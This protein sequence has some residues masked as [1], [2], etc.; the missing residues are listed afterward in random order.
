MQK[1]P[2]YLGYD[3][4]SAAGDV[5]ELATRM[6]SA[7]A[8]GLNGVIVPLR[9]SIQRKQPFFAFDTMPAYSEAH[10]L[11][12]AKIGAV[13]PQQNPEQKSVHAVVVAFSA[14]S[15]RPIAFFD[16]DAATHLKCAAVTALVTDLCAADDAQVMGLIGSGAQARAQLRA[17]AAVRPLK[18][19]NVYSRNESRVALFI[20]ENQPRFPGITLTACCSAEESVR[21]A[22]IVSTATT[23]V[24]PVVTAQSLERSGLHINCLGN[25]TPQSREI[26]IEILESRSV[27]IVED[28]RTAIEEAGE[29][30]RM[31]VTLDQIGDLGLERLK[32]ERTVFSSTGHAFLDLLTVDHLMESFGLEQRT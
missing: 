32:R 21:D 2:L 15:G 22:D 8:A 6:S 3:E 27:L 16:G 18:Q 11:F 12:V 19:V 5:V 7:Y 20:S 10:R 24:D 4:L 17:V 13:I 9:S 28:L 25:H 23:S 29:V 26:P 1:G 14:T 31:A 30:H